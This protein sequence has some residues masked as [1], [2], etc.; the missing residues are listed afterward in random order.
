[1]T[2][3]ERQSRIIIAAGISPAWLW[4]RTDRGWLDLCYELV[5]AGVVVLTDSG[6]EVC[7]VAP[8]EQLIQHAGGIA[9]LLSK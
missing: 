9:A 2:I 6:P 3:S 7:Q 4:K 1:M 5:T 8:A